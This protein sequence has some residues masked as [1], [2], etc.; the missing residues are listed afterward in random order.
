MKFE[1]IV[2]NAD[3][4]VHPDP[5][6][7]W[8]RVAVIC[9]WKDA[10][11]FRKRWPHAAVVGPLR[12][13]RGI[14][15]LVRNL[16][17]NPQIRVVVLD[18]PDLTPGEE[19]TRALR[20]AWETLPEGLVGADAWGSWSRARGDVRLVTREEAEGALRHAKLFGIPDTIDPTDPGFAGIMSAHLI[21]LGLHEDRPGGQI[22]LPP[23]PPKATAPAPHGDPGE[24]VAAD[25]LAEL[26]PMVLQRAMRFGQI[27]PTQYGD[28][29]ELLCLVGVVRD[30]EG[31]L[32]NLQAHGVGRAVLNKALADGNLTGGFTAEEAGVNVPQSSWRE[33]KHPI[34][35]ISWSQ[36]EAYRDQVAGLVPPTDRP[37]SYGSRMRGLDSEDQDLLAW[38]LADELSKLDF[39]AGR[40]E[41][42]PIARRAIERGQ[43]VYPDQFTAV[44]EM[45]RASPGTRAAYLTPWRPAEDAGKESGRPCIVGAWFRVEPGE[46][47]LYAKENPDQ[48]LRRVQIWGY[49][50]PGCDDPEV[51]SFEATEPILHIV[52]AFRS[53]DLYGAYP[54]NLAGIMLWQSETAKRLGMKVGTLTITSY[55]AHVYARDWAATDAVVETHSPK[56]PFWDQRSTWRVEQIEVSQPWP[57]IGSEVTYVHE[58]PWG[59]AV[60]TW[61]IERYQYRE[62]EKDPWDVTLVPTKVKYTN[63]EPIILLS[64]MDLIGIRPR[65]K[66][67]L[68]ATALTPDGKNVI[69]VFEAETAEGLRGMIERS[70]LVTSIGAALWLGDEI[71]RKA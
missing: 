49:Q 44:E 23:P 33:V 68:R 3:L 21:A 71:R 1:P 11:A 4:D 47:V 29:R 53:H 17:H 40:N 42:V 6:G 9:R 15:E 16:L 46:A 30:V 55:S 34:L 67:M 63:M 10:H 57:E 62:G 43:K 58:R 2:L 60:G 7:L 13:V 26:W 38:G 18:G 35:G 31:S 32:A 65:Q 66:F 70:G 5:P 12:T 8:S 56:G 48:I 37:Y 50:V 51:H 28:T 61:R 27:M 59:S 41:Q 25:T 54:T 14:D 24:R 36:V 45:L 52:V 64:T 19:T 20:H 22:T 69:Q 39:Y